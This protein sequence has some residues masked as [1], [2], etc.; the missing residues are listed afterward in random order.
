MRSIKNGIGHR[1]T[2]ALKSP[3]SKE[4]Q[5]MKS[6]FTVLLREA[7]VKA[8]L[9]QEKTVLRASQGLGHVQILYSILFLVTIF[10]FPYITIQGSLI[11]IIS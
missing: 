8:S 10:L 1:K 2:K 7:P 11:V 6:T 4:E 9:C 5:R 3:V